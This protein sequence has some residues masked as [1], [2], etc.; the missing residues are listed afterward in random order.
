[1]VGPSSTSRDATSFG[2]PDTR[3]LGR[4]T[5]RPF[6]I[7]WRRCAILRPKDD[8]P[9][10]PCIGGE[11]KGEAVG[12]NN[13]PAGLASGVSLRTKGPRP[14]KQNVRGDQMKLEIKPAP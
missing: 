2:N 5:G 13:R 11:W 8:P 6:L 4:N 1:M 12:P 7:D 14:V 10:R 3:P 9:G